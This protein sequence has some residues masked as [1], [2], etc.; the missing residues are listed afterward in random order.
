MRAR[1]GTGDFLKLNKRNCSIRIKLTPFGADFLQVI[2]DIG[3]DHHVFYPS[4]AMGGQFSLFLDAVYSIYDE[5][6]DDHRVFRRYDIKDHQDVSFTDPTVP[7]GQIRKKA[8]I[9]WDEEGHM[10]DISF[11]RMGR[12]NCPV[13]ELSGP[14]PVKVL[15]DD[16]Y[17]KD[18]HE[19][20]VDGR[21]LCYAVARACTKALKTYGIGGY[22]RSTAEEIVDGDRLDIDHLL[23]IKAYTLDAME[24]RELKE[25]WR[26]SWHSWPGA[27]Y[28]PFEKEMELLLFD[29]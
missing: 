14:D 22:Y 28:T 6:F 26:R 5:G 7:E 10:I 4:A 18:I 21:D 8:E 1:Y 20:V 2:W 25:R 9:S 13:R 15:I 29:M 16:S 24:V 19:Y 12:W 27:D 23:F 11:E 3:G 17:G